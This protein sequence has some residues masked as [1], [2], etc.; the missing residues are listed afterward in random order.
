[1]LENPQLK[2]EKLYIEPY[3]TKTKKLQWNKIC[4]GRGHKCVDFLVQ[5]HPWRPP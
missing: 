4:A 1:M 2:R 3:L 5:E